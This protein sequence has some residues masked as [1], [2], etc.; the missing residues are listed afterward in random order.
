MPG[1]ASRTVARVAVAVRTSIFAPQIASSRIAHPA[2]RAAGCATRANN[3]LGSSAQWP[4]TAT[5]SGLLSDDPAKNPHFHDW[6]LL[7]M[8]YCDGEVRAQ[9]RQGF[10]TRS[11]HVPPHPHADDSSRAA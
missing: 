2:P 1:S 6:N 5:V 4:P 3:A 7:F 8:K 9:T 10:V 11:P